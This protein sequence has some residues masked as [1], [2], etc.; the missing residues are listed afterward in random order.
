MHVHF[1]CIY[2]WKA[3]QKEGTL[4]FA[5]IQIYHLAMTNGYATYTNMS[6]RN[7]R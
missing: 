2:Y 5:L 4:W 6:R 7:C 3:L 1:L